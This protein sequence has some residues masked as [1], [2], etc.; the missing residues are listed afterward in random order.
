MIMTRD[1]NDKNT[2]K[3]PVRQSSGRDEFS[4]VAFVDHGGGQSSQLVIIANEIFIDANVSFGIQP[5][6]Q[7][8]CGR[9]FLFQVQSFLFVLLKPHAHFC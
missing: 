6:P 1:K 9:T 7:N 2:Q 3:H 8:N 5:L 4:A